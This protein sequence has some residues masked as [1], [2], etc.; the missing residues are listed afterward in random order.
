MRT[1]IPEYMTES[2]A[3]TQTQN[4]NLTVSALT[5]RELVELLGTE[6]KMDALREILAAIRET[7]DELKAEI[8][9][10]E[11]IAEATDSKKTC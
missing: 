6:T 8:D 4:E 10:L 11:H 3:F 1:F 9:R 5:L 7:N 2:K